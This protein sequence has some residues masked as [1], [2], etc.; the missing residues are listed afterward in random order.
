MKQLTIINNHSFVDVITNSS[1]ELFVLDAHKSLD[2]FKTLLNE[3]I[4][5]YN[6]KVQ[7]GELDENWGNGNKHRPREAV[8]DDFGEPYIYTKYMYTRD[9]NDDD[10]YL[11]QELKEYN[12][13]IADGEKPWY[14]PSSS[15]WGY[16]REDNIGKII[17]Q[18]SSD[19]TIPYEMWDMINDIFNGV[20]YHLG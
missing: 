10:E 1:T 5:E 8:L 18:S 11:D 13:K 4:E 14:K 7:S 12:K 6:L 9:K 17:L 19:N 15:L 3:L 2:I 16:E 20:N